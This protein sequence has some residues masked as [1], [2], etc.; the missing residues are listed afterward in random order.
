[1]NINELFE[2]LQNNFFP[3]ELK[4]EFQ[5]QGNCIVW[6]Y[7][8]DKDTEEI[9]MPDKNDDDDF[10]FESRSSE[11]LLQEVY[12]NDF[13]KL[14]IF[15]DELDEPYNWNFSEPDTIKNIISFKIF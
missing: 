12:D 8:L 14:Q 7:N 15:L 2:E 11:E 13:E 4:G 10:D 5:L 1:M 6:T 3:E 9:E